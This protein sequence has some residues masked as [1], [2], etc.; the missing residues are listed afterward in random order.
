LWVNGCSHPAGR[1]SDDGTRPSAS[2]VNSS[3][4]TAA[5][6]ATIFGTRVAIGVALPPVASASAM[7]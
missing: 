5:V 2:I 6:V 4:A 7:A 3:L 1:E